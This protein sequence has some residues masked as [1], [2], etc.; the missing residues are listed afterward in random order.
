MLFIIFT[1]LCL[2]LREFHANPIPDLEPHLPPKRNRPLTVKQPFNLDTD[3]RGA[4]KAEEWSKKVWQ[5][6][7]S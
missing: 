7:T 2:Q 3:N 6:F 4:R 1:Y 5:Y